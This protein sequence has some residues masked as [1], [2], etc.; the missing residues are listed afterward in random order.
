LKKKSGRTQPGTLDGLK[1][2]DHAERDEILS[3][4]TLTQI[5]PPLEGEEKGEE[6]SPTFTKT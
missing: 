6:Y 5:L 3:M 2:H 1:K 4:K